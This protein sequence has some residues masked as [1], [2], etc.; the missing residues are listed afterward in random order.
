MIQP[1]T[2]T[3]DL[4]LSITESCEIL[5]EQTHRKPEE[6]LDFKKINSREAFHFSPPIHLK[7]DWKIGLVDI[8]IYNSIFS[9]TVENNKFDLYTDTDEFSFEELKD[10]SEE[11]LKV[12]K[13]TDDPLE[14]ETIGPRIIETFWKLRSEK[15]STD[16]YIIFLMDYA[17]SPF[18]DFESYPRI[19]V[20]LDEDGTR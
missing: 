4:L 3:E 15:S 8:E 16:G 17:K 10:E 11:I 14:D 9:I 2:E 6:T 5:I 1:K 12:P 18:R 7:G 13:I 19:V 20:G